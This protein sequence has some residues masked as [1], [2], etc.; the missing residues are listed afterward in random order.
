MDQAPLSEGWTK[1]SDMTI[2]ATHAAVVRTPVSALRRGADAAEAT[3]FRLASSNWMN[4]ELGCLGSA[5]LDLLDTAPHLPTFGEHEHA[6]DGETDDAGG[7]ANN[8]ERVGAS[9]L[10]GS[11]RGLLSSGRRSSTRIG[12]ESDF[13]S[14]LLSFLSDF[15]SDFLL[16]LLI[17]L[18]GSPSCWA[19]CPW[20]RSWSTPSSWSSAY[21]PGDSLPPL[22]AGGEP[23][24]VPRASASTGT[25]ASAA[26]AAIGAR[27]AIAAR[28]NSILGPLGIQRQ[29]GRH[30]R[31]E[32][33]RPRASLIGE[34]TAESVA[35][36]RRIGRLDQLA[37]VRSN[38]LS[39]ASRPRRWN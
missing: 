13:L 36:A 23:E 18:I 33:I 10:L 27:T 5:S 30:R 20:S 35:I 19:C 22:R 26:I 29:I 25:V 15:L 8:G 2:S 9:L 4:D 6:D 12:L 39:V 17:G 21:D 7:N 38:K 32:V 28:V 1:P 34:P 24:P 16:V 37:V 3:P 31:T 11:T 14:D